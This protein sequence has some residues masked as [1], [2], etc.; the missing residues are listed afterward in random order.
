LF[1]KSNSAYKLTYHFNVA[2]KERSLNFNIYFIDS[3]GGK[4]IWQKISLL[5]KKSNEFDFWQADN[6]EFKTPENLQSC[7]IEIVSPD[8]TGKIWLDD[9]NIVEN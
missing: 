4:K 3:V 1:L 6:L 7:F 9:L 8:S 2:I 5:G